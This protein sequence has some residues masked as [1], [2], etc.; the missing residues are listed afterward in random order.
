MSFQ[1]IQ[2]KLKA[3]KSQFNEFGK[4]KYRNQED[5]LEALKPVLAEYEYSIVINDYIEEIAGR[6]YVKA[7]VHLYDSDMKPIAS[8]SA[9]AREPAEKKGMDAAQITGATSSYA[10]KHALNGLFAIDDTKDADSHKPENGKDETPQ[11]KITDSQLSQIT[12]LI[13]ETGAN[14]AKFC[15][16]LGVHKIEDLPVKDFNKAIRALENK[17][18]GAA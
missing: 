5:I 18:N 10:R 16:Y 7:E 6:V 2:E 14:Y 13:Y 15:K 11:Q 4:Y 1:K 9:Y 8:S 12:D 3:P 17:K